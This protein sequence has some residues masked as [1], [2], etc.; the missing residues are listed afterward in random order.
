MRKKK[1]TEEFTCEHCGETFEND[2][3]DKEALKEAEQWGKNPPGGL[4]I[5]CDD[6][7]N[8]FMGWADKKGLLKN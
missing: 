1:T 2:W 3:S 7:Y 4:S 6:C 8:K 5:I